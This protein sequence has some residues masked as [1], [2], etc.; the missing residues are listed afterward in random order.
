MNAAR[1]V[2][3]DWFELVALEDGR[4]A[5]GVGDVCGKGVPAAL[6]IG[7]TKTLIRINLRER[8]DLPGAI[9]KANAYLA[10]NNA[11]EL[12]ATLLYAA[13]DPRSGEVE[14]RELRPPS[15]ADAPRRRR[16]RKA[17]GRRPAGR[18]VRNPADKGT[19]RTA[20]AKA[21]SFFS[22]PT[23]SPKRAT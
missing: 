8:P 11:A 18:P 12:F 4:V 16:G 21:T 14:Y 23:A 1:D 6:F 17:A 7:I 20:C 3:G 15:G 9:L 13:F 10:N 19:L 5:V 2:G 22:T